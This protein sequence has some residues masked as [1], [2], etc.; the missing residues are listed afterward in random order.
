VKALNLLFVSLTCPSVWLCGPLRFADSFDV[1]CGL[2][3]DIG[4]LGARKITIH[5]Q[6]HWR[7]ISITILMFASTMSLGL[8]SRLKCYMYSWTI[9]ESKYKYHWI[10]RP[11]RGQIWVHTPIKSVDLWTI[12]LNLR[13]HETTCLLGF[14]SKLF[15]DFL[16]PTRPICA[17]RNIINH[18]YR[19]SAMCDGK[20]WSGRLGWAIPSVFL[21]TS[22]RPVLH[23]LASNAAPGRR[24]R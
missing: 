22:G 10:A 11:G 23:F 18:H 4:P 17:N 9:D 24:V 6:Y 7:W 1:V 19:V 21:A 13:S 14:T 3:G 2:I 15:S 12:K 5:T 8:P 20:S 16:Y